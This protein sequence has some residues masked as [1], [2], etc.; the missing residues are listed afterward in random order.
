MIQTLSITGMSQR[1]CKEE[2]RT[3]DWMPPYRRREVPNTFL[4]HWQTFW[5][6]DSPGNRSKRWFENLASKPSV[7][8]KGKPTIAELELKSTPNNWF[9]VS[10]VSYGMY[11]SHSWPWDERRSSFEIVRVRN[12]FSYKFRIELLNLFYRPEANRL[13]SL[14]KCIQ[15]R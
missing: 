2:P 13:E 8:C 9:V 1:V 4:H 5:I 11:W 12:S 6:A 15:Q 3:L 14:V 10:Q 7:T